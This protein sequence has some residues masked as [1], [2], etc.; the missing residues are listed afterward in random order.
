MTNDTVLL[1]F[2]TEK[3]LKLQEEYDKIQTAYQKLI[4]DYEICATEL[5]DKQ[6][7]L[8]AIRAGHRNKH[9]SYS[10]PFG[11]DN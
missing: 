10:Y 6:R 11:E 4:H 5:L 1:E 7:E 3:L 8:D 2:F 9:G